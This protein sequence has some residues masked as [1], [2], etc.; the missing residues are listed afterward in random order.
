[1]EPV[2]DTVQQQL[3]PLVFLHAQCH[4]L[5]VDEAVA[6]CAGA[7]E[8]FAARIL[9]V[10]VREQGGSVDCGKNDQLLG[11]LYR[12]PRSPAD[13]ER[14][15]SVGRAPKTSS[16]RHTTRRCMLLARLELLL[17]AVGIAGLLRRC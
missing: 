3:L 9:L 16:G 11:N 17:D 8:H 5:L 7:R 6:L 4:C 1:M 13:L 14:R 15:R 10:L 2:Q 12:L